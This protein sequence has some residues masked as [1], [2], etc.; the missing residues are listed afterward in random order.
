M[1]R[2]ILALAVIGAPALA[3]DDVGRQIAASAASAQ[4]LQGSLD[5][6][7]TLAGRGGVTL[8]TL[9]IGDPP[10]HSALGCAWRDPAGARGYADCRRRGGR[11]EVRLATGVS[12]RLEREGPRIWRGTMVR[13]GRAESVTLRRS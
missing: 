3:Q 10:T 4:T 2:L 6:T 5:G 7:W 1:K 8:Y 11:L 9:A 12:L 13:G